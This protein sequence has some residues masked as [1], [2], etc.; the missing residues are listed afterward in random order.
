MGKSFV[1]PKT[2]Q[3]FRLLADGTVEVQDPSGQ[4]GVFTRDGGWL[5]GDLRY[6]D[7]VM[8]DFVGGTYT[9]QHPAS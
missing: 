3:V 5:S 4:S 1:H 6:A 8:C 2:K 9:P 7:A